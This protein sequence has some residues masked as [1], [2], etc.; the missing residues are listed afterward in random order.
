M[1]HMPY[2]E[3]IK[4]LKNLRDNCE[5]HETKFNEFGYEKTSTYWKGKKDAIND[6]LKALH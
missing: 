3:M 5:Y 6:L 4:Y 2:E 1:P